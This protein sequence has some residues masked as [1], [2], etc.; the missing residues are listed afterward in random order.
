MKN[1][2]NEDNQTHNFISS[3]GSGTVINYGS[4][5]GSTSQKV[6]VPTVT[7]PVPQRLFQGKPQTVFPSIWGLDGELKIWGLAFRVGIVIV[8]IMFAVVIPHFSILMGF[9]GNFTGCLLSFV[10]PCVFHLYIRYM[11]PMSN[12]VSLLDYT[13]ERCFIQQRLICRSSDSTI[14]R[15]MLRL[16]PCNVSICSQTL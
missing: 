13:D 16:N 8:T 1:M 2:L 6:T 9:I 12:F 10:W 11:S 14:C 4:G 3:S 15:R 5:S 7:V